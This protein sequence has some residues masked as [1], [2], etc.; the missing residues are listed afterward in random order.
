MSRERFTLH[1][2]NRCHPRMVNSVAIAVLVVG[3]AT[4]PISAHAAGCSR[5]S[6]KG[7][8]GFQ[9]TVMQNNDVPPAF[10]ELV[11]TFH[12][13]GLGNALENFVFASSNGSVGQDSAAITYSVAPD[14]TFS[15]TQNNGETFSGVIVADGQEFYFI[16]TSGA[17]CGSSIIRRGHALRLH[18]AS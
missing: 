14:C 13:D 15:M 6:L 11:G 7:T 2:S 10:L 5:A 3:L 9:S 12:F 18:A 4:L 17:C 16:E 8:Y 1:L